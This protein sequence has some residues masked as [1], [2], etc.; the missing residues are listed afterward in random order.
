MPRRI[1]Y[2]GKWYREWVYNPHPSC[3]T[4]NITKTAMMEPFALL[5][6]LTKIYPFQCR[7]G[8]P[9]NVLSLT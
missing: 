2:T 8:L 6:A 3:Y 5:V 4:T 1:T 9:G 7:V